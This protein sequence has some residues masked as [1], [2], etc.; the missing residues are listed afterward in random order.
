MQIRRAAENAAALTQK[1]LA[2]SRRQVLQSDPV[3]FRSML[4]NLLQLVRGAVG[5]DI[6]VSTQMGEDLWPILADPGAART[7]DRQPRDQR[8][9]RDAERRHA[10]DQRAQ[11]AA[12]ATAS[13]VPT[14]T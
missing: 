12:A 2:F 14:P 10:A 7:I 3:D 6:T 11:R 13:A 8:A 1:L 5:E 9:R 4:G